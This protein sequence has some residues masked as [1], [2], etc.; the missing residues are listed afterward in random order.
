MPMLLRLA[1]KPPKHEGEQDNGGNC[2]GDLGVRE[3]ATQEKTERSG[4]EGDGQRSQEVE[5]EGCGT[6]G[7]EAN[8]PVDDHRKEE[9]KQDVEWHGADELAQV[10]VGDAVHPV[11]LLSN[12]EI[13]FEGNYLNKKKQNQ[14]WW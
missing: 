2:D 3:H 14:I 5:K 13:A 10:V 7:V 11:A 12:E 6:G 4:R 1:K 9:S 8:H